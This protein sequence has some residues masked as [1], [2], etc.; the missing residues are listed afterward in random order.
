MTSRNIDHKTTCIVLCLYSGKLSALCFSCLNAQAPK[1]QN[2]Y[3]P[4]WEV[5][6]EYTPPLLGHSG[7]F[8]G[9]NS[10]SHVD[11]STDRRRHLIKFSDASEKQGGKAPLC[12]SGAFTPRNSQ[13]IVLSSRI[14]AF[15]LAKPSRKILRAPA[16]SKNLQ[17]RKS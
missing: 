17:K 15:Q 2:L 12:A 1:T 11:A 6:S 7:A 13:N 4:P 3:H 16:E 9:Q 8:N 10:E 14:L 5:P